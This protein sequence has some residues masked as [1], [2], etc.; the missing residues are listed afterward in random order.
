MLTMPS[1]A[2][3][4]GQLNWIEISYK[5][6]R[7]GFLYEKQVCRSFHYILSF[8]SLVPLF[9]EGRFLPVL[10]SAEISFSSVFMSYVFMVCFVYN[11]W[12]IEEKLEKLLLHLKKILWWY[13]WVFS[14][15]VSTNMVFVSRMQVCSLSHLSADKYRHK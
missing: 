5:W 3:H 14:V 7:S 12:W 15:I 6:K 1:Y 2:D 9:I 4:N 10:C 11:K 8:R 13:C